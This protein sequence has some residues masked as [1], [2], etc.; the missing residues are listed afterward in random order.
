MTS[1]EVKRALVGYC[2]QYQLLGILEASTPG[3]RFDF[4]WIRPSFSKPETAGVEI[5]VSRA[6]FLSD[7]KWHHYLPYCE[8]FYFACPA[9][10]I[11]ESELTPEVGLIWIDADGNASFV[12]RAKRRPMETENRIK[13]L[14]RV[15]FKLHFKPEIQ[16][17]AAHPATTQEGK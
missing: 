13:M 2:S 10:L 1:E 8:K 16:D 9:G 11:Q 17:E 6:D 12:K 5:K 3:H 4:W 14:M 15:I 7:K